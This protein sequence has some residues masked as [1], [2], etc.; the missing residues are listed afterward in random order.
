MSF[1][2]LLGRVGSV[3]ARPEERSEDLASLSKLVISGEFRD[4]EFTPELYTAL[5]RLVTCACTWKGETA[6]ADVVLA[7]K[8]FWGAVNAPEFDAQVA[9]AEL[10]DEFLWTIAGR[11]DGRAASEEVPFLRNILLW[12][13]DRF[14]ARRP[15]VR[16]M[17]GR[18]LA[19]FVQVKRKDA[20]V[21]AMLQVLAPIIRGFGSP[22]TRAHKTLLLDVLMPLHK[23]NEWLVWDRQ[24]PLLGMYHKELVL[25]ME[26]LLE[27]Q[28]SLSAKCLEALCTYFPQ[29]HESNTPKDVL[30]IFEMGRLL[31]FAD[32]ASF[33]EAL[34]HLLKHW[35]RLIGSQNAQPIQAVLQ[36]WKDDHFVELSRSA[37]LDIISQ[38]LPVLLRGGEVFWNPTVNRMTAL[39]LERLEASNPEEFERAA[40]ALWGSG[41]QTPAYELA[42]AAPPVEEVEDEQPENASKKPAPAPNVAS[43]NFRM[44][45]WKPPTGGGGSSIGGQPPLTATGVAPWA[46]QNHNAGF[47]GGAGPLKVGGG[48]PFG[49]NKQP[50]LTTT[51]VAPWAF[52]PKQKPLRP[53]GMPPSAASRPPLGGERTFA[54]PD[55][56]GLSFAEEDEEAEGEEAADG[57]AAL[58]QSTAGGSSSSSRSGLER[59]REYMRR[60]CPEGSEQDAAGDPAWETALSAETPTLLP[61]LKFHQLVFGHRDLG[62]GAFSVVQY[63][64]TIEKGKTQ[65]QWAEYAVKV[66]NTKTMEELGYERSV[67]REICVLRMLSHPNIARL[68]SSF[69]YKDGAY[70]VLEYA[71]K[72]DLHNFI[73][74]A[75]KLEEETARFFLGE[76]IAALTAIHDIGFMYG[77]LKPENIVITAT[78]HAKLTDF[79][80]CRPLTEEARAKTNDSILRRLRN[81]DWKVLDDEAAAAASDV[82]DKLTAEDHRVEGTTMYLPPEVVRGGVPTMGADAW[83]LGCLVYQLLTGRPPIW[84]ESELE[85]DLRSR[86]VSFRLESCIQDL[87]ESARQLA[88]ALLEV[89]PLK[90]CSV[91]QAAS[92]GFFA[93]TDVFSLYKRPR[94][95][96]L[97]AVDLSAPPPEGDARWQ[98]RQLSKIWSVLPSASDYVMPT[99]LVGGPA[100]PNNAAAPTV[101]A[102]S[103]IERASPFADEAYAPMSAARIQSL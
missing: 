87:Q 55:D 1:I 40:E 4:C 45:G 36:L 25:C 58:P 12:L 68:V 23:P 43:F 30:L 80:G 84:A 59:V 96:T 66:I 35:L 57:V 27:R 21:A 29:S 48:G 32:P 24:T 77:D 41:G 101:I 78:N 89:D 54:R 16:A 47:R 81:G 79:G 37:S 52:Q 72:G 90:R 8:V 50:P 86:I 67:N 10:S 75:G 13:Y 46:M 31:R 88:G 92:D 34:P 85:E 98:K 83:A 18:S 14:P 71:K 26:L 39:V 20:P 76:V 70:L 56:A 94:G 11:T 6:K 9:D 61:T 42:D 63:A 73:V 49:G 28:P 97:P 100:G 62:K 38:L 22:P 19:T 44:G 95:P 91:A 3:T 60:L 51:G 5:F 15:Q 69:R 103:D 7:D 65:S 74:Q 93:G 53:P 82:V 64:R 102:E 17:I 33:Q 2:E 99:A